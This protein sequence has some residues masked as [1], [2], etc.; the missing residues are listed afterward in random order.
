MPIDHKKSDSRLPANL[1]PATAEGAPGELAVT[2]I[3]VH[4][5]VMAHVR[6]LCASAGVNMNQFLI[7]ACCAVHSDP[8]WTAMVQGQAARESTLGNRLETI[9]RNRDVTPVA[10]AEPIDADLVELAELTELAS[11]DPARSRARRRR[12]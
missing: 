9:R 12:N 5:A 4:P 2:S 11:P 7:I 3:R 10:S 1:N 6:S 8:A